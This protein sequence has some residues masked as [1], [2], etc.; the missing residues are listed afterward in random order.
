MKRPLFLLLLG[1]SFLCAHA[2]HITGGTIS[3]TFLGQS[4][5]NYQYSVTLSLYRD[6]FSTGAPLDASAPIAIFDKGTG[7]MVW[8]NSIVM[9]DSVHLHLIAPSP[10]INNPPTIFYDVGHYTFT[11]SLPA[12]NSGYV[13]AYQRC[14]RIG[15]INNVINS[16]SVGA[17]YTAEIPGNSVLPTA[18]ENNSALF[19]GKDTVDVCAG[20]PFKYDFGA[21]DEDHDSL[22]YYFCSAYLGGSTGVSAP[23]PPLRPPYISV[24]YAAPFN[25]SQPLGP[26]VTLNT[27]NG[28]ISG[29][30]PDAGIY[31]VTVCVNEY[32]NGVLI[33]TQHKDLQIKVADCSLTTPQLD[34][35]YIT[36][37]GYN[38]TFSNH[39]NNSLVHTYEWSFGDGTQSAATT[40]TH[41]YADTGVYVVK[42]VVNKGEACSDS[43]N[44]LAKVYPGFFPGFTY[45]GVCLNHPTQFTDTTRTA[46][47]SVNAWSWSFGDPANST[48][49]QQNPAFTYTQIGQVSV[50]FIVS[51]NKGCVDT[52][53]QTVS[54]VDKPPIGVK[55]K[56][57]LICKGDALQ[58][59]AIGTGNFTWTPGTNIIN[60]NTATPTVSPPATTNYFVDLNQ[61][62]CTNRDTVRVR[63]ATFINLTPRTDTVI[64]AGDPVQLGAVSNGLHYTWTPAGSLNDPNIVNPIATPSVTTIYQVTAYLGGCAPATGQ[65]TVNTVPYPG[66]NAGADMTVCYQTAAQIHASITGSSFTWSPSNSLSNPNSLNPIATP[67]VTTT[68][69]LTV[70]DVL[71]CPKPGRDTVVVTVLPKVN[72]YAGRDTSVVVGQPLQ[73]EASGGSGYL[74]TP[75][76]ALNQVTIPDPVGTYDGSFDSIR[77]K[78]YVRDQNGC[79]DSSTV[80][81]RVFRT[82]PRIFVPNAFTPNGDGK[83]DQFRPIAV[84]IARIEYFRVYNRWGQLVFETTTNEQGWDGRVAGSPQATGTFVWMVKAIDYAGRPVFAK[85]TA[86]L[87]R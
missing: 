66:A 36:C 74:W 77:Y 27:L 82:D 45:A 61:D 39:N 69:I 65:V 83:N 57:T 62:G 54:I 48:S 60:A 34:P 3:Y 53:T 46:Y 64:C 11:V 38:L 84:G 16:N 86:T 25:E 5:G 20:N 23:N 78:V 17:T 76:T 47:G 41:T 49:Q 40:P 50:R 10:C 42:L 71:G 70:R 1:F 58:L 44:A 37:D 9:H 87:I 12:S 7:T 18:P 56:D 15:G 21:I 73:L 14:C 2:N 52:V 4:G 35:Q 32:R 72:A 51:S 24:P 26:T 67:L 33:A 22:S 68:Y 79:T 85:G 75:G 8:N 28:M 29:I 31:V 43:A 6:H 63:V 80:R 81:V 13:I 59:A 19:T 30:A 55:F